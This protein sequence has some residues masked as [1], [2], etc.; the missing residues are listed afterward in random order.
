[1]CW[2]GG[3]C[4]VP[5]LGF[6]PDG[7]LVEMVIRKNAYFHAEHLLVNINPCTSNP[8]PTVD[9]T[10]TYKYHTDAPANSTRSQQNIH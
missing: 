8:G 10:I 5:G 9:G 1:M 3:G 4:R 6:V 7:W 2:L